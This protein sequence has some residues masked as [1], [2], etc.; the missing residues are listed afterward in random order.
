[1]KIIPFRGLL[2]NLSL[3]PDQHH[4]FE[5]VK[6]QFNTFQQMNYFLPPQPPAFYVFRMQHPRQTATG[7][8]CTT[9]I[10]D[11]LQ[12]KV[13]K[14]EKTIRNKE[15]IQIDLLK[16][17]GVAVK[18]ALLVHRHEAQ[19]REWLHLYTLRHP[20]VQEVNFQDGERHI[21]WQVSSATDIQELQG[22]Y[23][24]KLSRVAIA[25]GH[26]RFASF[27]RLY[28]EGHSGTDEYSAVMTAYFPE[29]E[30]KIEAFHRLVEWPDAGQQHLLQ[31]L[32]GLGKLLRL[33]RPRLPRYK[34]QM[35]IVLSSRSWY[36]FEWAPTVLARE[37]REKPLLDVDLLHHQ[38]LIPLLKVQN[39]RT[40]RRIH[41]LEGLEDPVQL[42]TAL[43]SYPPGICF[44]LHPIDPTDFLQIANLGLTLVPKATFFQPRLKNGL[45]VQP[46]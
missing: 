19:I 33:D 9:H 42:E 4:F 7:L 40:D 16:E 10:E 11:Y 45:I 24:E 2:P 14:H 13:L 3:I 43:R 22:L 30:L 36:H 35:S 6:E 20:P 12:G 5:S 18:P 37:T 28:R 44:V 39:I 34:H 38:I 32:A 23:G 8:I 29:D 21:L 31:Q 1:M 15:Q 26:H 17:R 27:A 25:D 41:Y 46:L